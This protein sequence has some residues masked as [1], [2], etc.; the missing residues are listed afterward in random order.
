M[1][2]I[3]IARKLAR[4]GA[5][6][7]ANQ[8]YFLAVQNG[9]LQPSEEFE[10][11]LYLLQNKGDYRISYTSFVRL[12]NQGWYQNDILALVDRVFY[13]PNISILKNRY[14]RNC[15]LLS[16]YPYLFRSDFPDFE[17]LPIR[18]YPF[19][20]HSG[21]LPYP[22]AERKFGGFINMRRQVVSQN[23]F[24]DLEKPILAEDVF[25]QYELEYL[26]D[27]VRRSEDVGR[28]NHVYLHYSDWGK[29][30]SYLQVLNMRPLLD[31][32]KLVFLIEEEVSQYPIDFKARFGI[33][34][35]EY[36]LRPVGIREIH[37]MIWHTQLSTHNGGD[38]F[39]EIFDNHPNLLAMPSMMLSHIEEGINTAREGLRL[40]TS[41]Q[42][43]MDRFKA[44]N[45]P[46]LV[47]ELYRLRQPTDKDL[48][49]ALYLAS[50]EWLSGVDWAS[51][52]SPAVFFQPHFHNISYTL[53]VDTHNRSV[54][55]AENV[56]QLRA[57]PIFRDFKY[58]KT[59]T[60]MRRFTTSHGAT[61]KFMY[62]NAKAQTKEEKE[63]EKK[64]GHSVVSDAVS[65]R[66]LNRSFMIDPDDRLY[67]DSVL[68]RFED[69][70]LNPR[71]T[72]TALAA[73]LD[74]PYTDSMTYCSVE[75]KKN[76]SSYDGNDIGFSVDAVYR[77]YSEYINSNEG[78]YIEY[79]LRDAYEY[80]GYTPQYYDGQ[81]VDEARVKEL[82]DGFTTMDHYIR[83]TWAKI[84]ENVVTISGGPEAQSEEEIQKQIQM[85]EQVQEQVQ[86]QLLEQQMATFRDSRFKNSKILS[87]GLHFINKNGQPLYMMPKLELDPALLEQ[88][89]YH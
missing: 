10:A 74:L 29:F 15:R 11:A 45:N 4:L 35:S 8:A 71:A 84:Y 46:R 89:L 42:D 87:S 24:K 30:C 39:N 81:P 48:L 58:I 3:E 86:S 83:D 26:K 37:R 82:I 88:P 25:S 32:K 53:N 50:P 44:W 36:P 79:F 75:G 9:G 6:Q 62:R 40:S 18:F 60:P 47:E 23:F 59:F 28:E 77:T 73:F 76:A 78:Y 68:V 1:E 65:E 72:F 21:Y 20:D 66:V 19:D 17:Q 52:I 38:F 54:L 63:A 80:Y 22:V 55:D 61:V 43:A 14:E 57:S 34:Y 70:K 64:S 67:R 41:L 69:G 56:R 2:A 85:Q 51:R 16:K 5:V 31:S 49:V 27:N 12:Y 7:D 13:E 33:D